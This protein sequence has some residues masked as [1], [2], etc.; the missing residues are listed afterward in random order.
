[1]AVSKLWSVKSRLGTVI[2]YA[3]NPDKTSAKVYTP[4]QYQALADVLLMQRMK[5]RLKKNFM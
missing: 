5:K 3:T 2:D 4:K 1:M